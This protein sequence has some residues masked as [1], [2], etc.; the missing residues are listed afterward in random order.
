MALARGSGSLSAPLAADRG[1]VPHTQDSQK[2]VPGWGMGGGGAPA[3][4]PT[5]ELQKRKV[6]P[7]ALPTSP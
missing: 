7:L 5:K 4:T 3:F 2:M 6:G 1:L